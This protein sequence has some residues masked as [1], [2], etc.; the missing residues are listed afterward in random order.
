MDHDSAFLFEN[1]FNDHCRNCID[2]RDSG[3]NSNRAEKIAVNNFHRFTFLNDGHSE[4]ER[5]ERKKFSIV[6]LEKTGHRH[7]ANDKEYNLR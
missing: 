7:R 3:Y 5:G 4:K 2:W 6:S 1:V